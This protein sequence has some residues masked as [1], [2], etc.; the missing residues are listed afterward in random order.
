MLSLQEVS[1][2]HFMEAFVPGENLPPTFKIPKPDI[3]DF[4]N[5][6]GMYP[7]LVCVSSSFG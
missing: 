1:V 4:G 2:A 7:G 3:A 5:E 6:R